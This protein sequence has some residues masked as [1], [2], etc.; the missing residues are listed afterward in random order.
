MAGRPI[1]STPTCHPGGTGKSP[2]VSLPVDSLIHDSFRTVPALQQ[3][4]LQAQLRWTRLG[5]VQQGRVVRCAP[6]HGG[7][8]TLGQ[9]PALREWMGLQPHGGY[10]LLGDVA[11]HNNHKHNK[12]Q[13]VSSIPLLTW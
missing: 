5:Q 4:Q 8:R 1:P 13:T 2:G 7:K 9:Q 6:R 12:Q 10:A 11:E 3:V